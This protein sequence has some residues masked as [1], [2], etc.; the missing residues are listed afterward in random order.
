MCHIS[1]LFNKESFSLS[2]LYRKTN[3]AIPLELGLAK[4]LDMERS[5]C[6]SVS[7]QGSR[8]HLSFVPTQLAA[9]NLCLEKVLQITVPLQPG[10][11]IAWSQK[12][13]LQSVYSYIWGLGFVQQN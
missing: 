12:Q 1:S 9:S 4:D 13:V 7:N 8:K 3:I 11:T 2:H 10:P 5:D 6:L